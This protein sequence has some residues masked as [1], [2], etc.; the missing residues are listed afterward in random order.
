VYRVRHLTL[1]TLHALQGADPGGSRRAGAAHPGRPGAG[2]ARASEHRPRSRTCS[3]CKA[4]RAPDGV[5][6]G[7]HA[8]ALARPVRSDAGRGHGAVSAAS[9]R[10][11]ATLTGATS[12][13]ATSSP[14]TSCSPWATGGSCRR[15]PTSGSRGSPARRVPQRDRRDARNPRVHGTRAVARREPRRS[16]RRS[17]VARVPALPAHGGGRALRRRRICGRSSTR[18]RPAT[19]WPPRALRPELAGTGEHVISRLLTVD[20]AR[21]PARRGPRSRLPRRRHRRF[22]R[23]TVP[24][25]PLHDPVPVTTP[26]PAWLSRSEGNARG[27]GA[28]RGD[29]DPRGDA[30]ASPAHPH[31]G[32]CSTWRG[33]PPLS[34]GVTLSPPETDAVDEWCAPGAWSPPRC[35]PRRPGHRGAS[36]S[37]RFAAVAAF[38]IG[39]GTLLGAVVGTAWFVR[40]GL[41]PEPTLERT[42]FAT[43]PATPAA[44]ATPLAETVPPAPPPPRRVAR[45][46][47]RGRARRSSTTARTACG[48]SGSGRPGRA[49]SQGGARGSLPDPGRVRGRAR[50]RPGG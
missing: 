24:S 32:G 22:C 26:H 12:C 6:G 50:G 45:P 46:E 10:A 37:S 21:T 28:R 23:P 36:R 5:R 39:S 43:A 15:C 4:C 8:R 9:A 34:S 13:T 16:A 48:S 3:T 7:H 41:E 38:L 18:W 47:P 17:V 42:A 1:G 14:G 20:A 33:A 2:R 30:G 35:P 44:I 31:S 11:S 19:T 29:A 25:R 27:T 49:R 40:G